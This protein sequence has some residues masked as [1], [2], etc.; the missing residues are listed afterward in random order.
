MTYFGI[1]QEQGWFGCQSVTVT[2]IGDEIWENAI[3]VV[4]DKPDPRV[5]LY[6]YF[7]GV[8]REEG[9]HDGMPRFVEQNKET[10]KAFES[11]IPSE[12]IYCNDLQRWI[13][14]HPNIYKTYSD[15]EFEEDS[16]TIYKTYSNSESK[17]V[18]ALFAL[19]KI[20]LKS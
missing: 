6:S 13:M 12:F 9:T 1:R 20:T 14:F 4:N 15:T 7:N 19:N 16:N 8:Y 10:D 5:L 11:T 18:R 2:Y 3:A 17:E